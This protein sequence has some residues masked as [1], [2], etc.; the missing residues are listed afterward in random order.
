MRSSSTPP[1]SSRAAVTG[2]P[3]LSSGENCVLVEDLE[4]MGPAVLELLAD[5][6]RRRELGCA[7]RATFLNH[8][9]REAVQPRFD[10]FIDEL[11]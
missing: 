11:R 3:E 7:G 5:A 8:F 10:Q 4:E 6:P 9:T 1:S 2:L